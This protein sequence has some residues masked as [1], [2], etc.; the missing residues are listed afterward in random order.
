MFEMFENNKKIPKQHL[1]EIWILEIDVYS[2][3]ETFLAIVCNIHWKN[4]RI[5][6][7]K[8]KRLRQR[9]RDKKTETKR[10]RQKDSDRKTER[11]KSDWEIMSQA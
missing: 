1:L 7:K 4:V 10:Q 9:H 5:K 3:I 6:K 2:I 8:K 11:E